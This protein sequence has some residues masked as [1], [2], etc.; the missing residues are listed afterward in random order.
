MMLSAVDQLHLFIY[1]APL[2]LGCILYAV[3]PL[4]KQNATTYPK[5]G[6]KNDGN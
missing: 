2:I 3:V 6:N 1:V 5:K 4:D